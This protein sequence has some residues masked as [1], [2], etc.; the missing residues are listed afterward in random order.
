MANSVDPDRIDKNGKLIQPGTPDSQGQTQA[1][2]V[3]IQEPGL[4]SDPNK[5]VFTEP[6][7][8]KPTEVVLPDGVTNKDVDQV[9]VVR[10][11]VLVV[12]VKDNSGIPAS[13]VEDLLA[14][15]GK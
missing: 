8:D 2:V 14:K 6:G 11:D 4:F 9:I 3:P 5:V 13:K 12:T 1:V 15:Y 10:P 7:K